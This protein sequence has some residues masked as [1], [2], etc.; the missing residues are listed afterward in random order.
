M[1]LKKLR[2]LHII[3][4]LELGGAQ[5]HV[6]EI[7]RSLDKVRFTVFLVSSN[8]GFL[9]KDAQDIPGVRTILLPSLTHPI[10]P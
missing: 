10:N 5:K 8:Q 6:L 3:T 7:V 1:K 2:I 9:V 4:Q